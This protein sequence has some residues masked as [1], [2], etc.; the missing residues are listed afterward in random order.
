VFNQRSIIPLPEMTSEQVIALGRL[1]L[2]IGGLL[3]IVI[4]PAQHPES[5]LEYAA[6]IAYVAF[7]IGLL[8][9]FYRD[10][11][12]FWNVVFHGV[13]IGL[14]CLIIRYTEGPTS[15]FFV[16]FTFLLFVAT[17][18]WQGRGALITGILLSFVLIRLSLSPLLVG[19]EEA[20]IDR[21]I[22]R[23]IYLLV[24]SGL[25]AFLGDQLARSHQRHERLQLA[26]DLHDGLL[27]VLAAVRFKLHAIAATDVGNSRALVLNVAGILEE[28]QRHLRTFVEQQRNDSRRDEDSMAD[29]VDE[30]QRHT[31][32]LRTLWN[33]QFEL[34]LPAAPL[35]LPAR[36]RSELRLILDEAVANAVDHGN[37]TA[38]AVAVTQ[39]ATD[40]WLTIKDNGSGFKD[41][42]GEFDQDMLNRGKVGPRSLVRRIMKSAGSLRLHTS[43]QGVEL[44]IRLPRLLVAESRR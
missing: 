27:Q 44:I 24:A 29:V 17:L 36:Q 3:A 2:S 21:L 9:V 35:Q 14:L 7:S 43:P 19:H 13:E 30:I 32:Q 33:C 28:E 31:E 15:P 37:A 40:I 26:L 23:S 12:D 4:D 1:V 39:D 34:D 6:L 16:Y 22:V 11:P 25:F 5:T 42:S 18:R 38:I 8:I 10:I 41:V 20:D